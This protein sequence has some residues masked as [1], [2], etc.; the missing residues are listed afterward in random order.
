MDLCIY[1]EIHLILLK[2][3]P[4]MMIQ[5]LPWLTEEFSHHVSWWYKTCPDCVETIKNPF[6]SWLNP[7]ACRHPLEQRPRDQ[8]WHPTGCSKK[9]QPLIFLLYIFLAKNCGAVFFSRILW[10]SL[11]IVT[12]HLFC[13]RTKIW[14]MIFVHLINICP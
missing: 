11:L 3:S 1:W 4:I 9:M 5:N 14:N 7:A 12:Y 10:F 8:T 13:S 2:N 6:Q